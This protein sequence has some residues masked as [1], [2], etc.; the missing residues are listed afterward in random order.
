METAVEI[1]AAAVLC[2]VLYSLMR[3]FEILTNDK[4]K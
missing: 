1:T 4:D 3:M 2:A